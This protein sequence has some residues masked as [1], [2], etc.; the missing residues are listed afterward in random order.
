M[1]GVNKV[2]L[3]GNTTRDTELRATKSGKPVANMR[4]ATNR[5]V[6]G[7]EL[8]QYH[9]VICWDKT[10]EV[11]GKYATKGRKVYVEGRIE[12]RA[13]KD[14]EGKEREAAEIIASDVQFLDSKRDAK[15][16]TATVDAEEIDPS[17]IPF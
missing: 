5:M 8:T 2:M 12:Y 6:N 15:G 16:A 9:T 11:T 10:A 17:E 13:Y 14:R 3:I 4:L 1:A 7:Q